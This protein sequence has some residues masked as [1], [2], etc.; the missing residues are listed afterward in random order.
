MM[1]TH[2]VDEAV[3]MSDRIVMMTNGPSATIGQVM[4][5]PTCPGRATASRW[6]RTRSTTIAGRIDPLHFL[7]EK[8]RKV[9][10]I[11]AAA[12]TTSRK[13]VLMRLLYCPFAA[14]TESSSPRRAPAGARAASSQGGL[15]SFGKYREIIIAVALFLLFDLGVLVLN[16][17]TSFKIDQD[18]V[19]INLAGRQR[20]VSQRV[21]RT[22]LELDAMRVAGAPYKP[23]TLAELRAGAKIFE[24]SHVAFKKAAPFPAAT[25]SRCSWSRWCPSRGRELEEKVDEL[26]EAL[27]RRCSSRC[28]GRRLHPAGPGRRAGLQPGQQHQAAE[29]RQRLRDGNAADRRLARQHAAHGADRRHR[30]GPAELRL[31]PVQVPAPPADLRRRDRSGHRG[32]PRNPHQS[33][34]EGL[35]LL[36]PDFQLGSQLSRSAHTLFGRNLVPGQNFFDVLEPLVSDKALTDAR[37]YVSCCSRRT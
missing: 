4:D 29:P 23:E 6:P 17:Y 25:A 8:Q 37:D 18:T 15:A 33:V 20:Y 14:S 27:L 5:V 11:S 3:L 28:C 24:I 9:E 10:P 2:D 22:L 16:F 21:A 19:A 36:T 1:I 31:H 32:E 30:A 35:F 26:W 7:Y 13:E 12:A 34:R